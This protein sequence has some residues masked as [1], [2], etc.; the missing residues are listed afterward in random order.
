MGWERTASNEVGV[1][2]DPDEEEVEVPRL[3]NPTVTTTAN[4]TECMIVDWTDE[5]RISELALNVCFA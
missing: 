4:V 2:V 5:L 3:N 1:E